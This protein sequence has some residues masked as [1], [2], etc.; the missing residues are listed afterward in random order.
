MSAREGG[1]GGW[2]LVVMVVCLYFDVVFCVFFRSLYSSSSTLF[3]LFTP[4]LPILNLSLPLL[5]Y[6]LIASHS[7]SHSHSTLTLTGSHSSS[8]RLGSISLLQLGS[9]PTRII[10]HSDHLPTRIIFPLS[11][12]DHLQLFYLSLI[13]SHSHSWIDSWIG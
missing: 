9:S 7:H 2:W 11:K 13:D 1:G 10:F 5:S 12:L 4:S 3:T 6:L 8:L